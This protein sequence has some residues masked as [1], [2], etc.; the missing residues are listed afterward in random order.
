[1]YPKTCT[2]YMMQ[3]LYCNKLN[4]NISPLKE[5]YDVTS[6]TTPH[7]SVELD[8]IHP[9]MREWLDSLG[10]TVPWIEIF[11][12]KSGQHGGVHT[13][14]IPGDFTKINWIYGGKNSKMIW[15]KITD[16]KALDRKPNTTSVETNYIAYAMS[17]VS[18]V[19]AEEL[20]GAYLLQ[21]GVPHIVLN[22]REDRYCLCFVLADKTGK[23]LT[24]PESYEL[25][26]DYING[27]G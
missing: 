22:P 4:L 2:K 26:K 13:D 12:R 10:I 20:L 14:S 24:M 9:A 15:Y 11:Y 16:P 17:E 21:V 27:A 23:R 3:N 5:E 6:V 7:T 25:L 18:P 8:M 1:M 19:Y